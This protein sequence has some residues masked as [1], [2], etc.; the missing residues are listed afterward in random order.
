MASPDLSSLLGLVPG[1]GTAMAA[2]VAPP[3]K[4]QPVKVN[5]SLAPEHADHLLG[6][7]SGAAPASAPSVPSEPT[8]GSVLGHGLGGLSLA[9]P[10]PAVMQ[11]PPSLLNNPHR[12]MWSKIGHGLLSTAEAVG[13]AEAPA[14]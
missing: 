9:P 14:I 2:S 1:Y 10:S 13:D 6:L 11:A 5:L 8:V 3:P 7:V 12:S 4:P